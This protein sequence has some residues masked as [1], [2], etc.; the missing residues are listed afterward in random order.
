MLFNL[1]LVDRSGKAAAIIPT[2]AE[3]IVVTV[4]GAGRGG[5]GV[6]LLGT[7]GRGS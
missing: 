2:A 6:V 4:V 7:G 1:T 5:S 3:D